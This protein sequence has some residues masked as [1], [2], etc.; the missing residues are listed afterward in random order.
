MTSAVEKLLNL[1]GTKVAGY[2]QLEG[3]ICL[4]LKFTS[5]GINCRHCQEYTQQFHQ[6]TFI[7]VRDLPTF[8]QPVYLKL[9]RRRFYCPRC[10]R[11]VT[12]KLEFIDWRQVYTRRYEQHIYQRVLSV[13]VE[14]VSR[15]EDLSSEVIQGI[16]KRVSNQL[17]KKTGVRSNV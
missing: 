17:K 15:E 2:Q 16:F 6:A 3:Y 9:P 14:Q 12:Q 4:H 8:G 11:Y 5:Q 13:S 10:Q 1:P 7:L